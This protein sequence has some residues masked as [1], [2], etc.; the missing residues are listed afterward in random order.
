MW[1]L[2]DPNVMPFITIDLF[3]VRGHDRTG[4]TL[5]MEPL[6]VFAMAANR[7]VE[8]ERDR[9]GICLDPRCR[10]PFG[11]E[12]KNRGKYCS[13]RCASYVH[14][15]KSR[16]KPLLKIVVAAKKGRAFFQW[17][18]LE[19]PRGDT[20]TVQ[21]AKAHIFDRLC[22][23]YHRNNRTNDLIDGETIRKDKNIPEDVFTWALSE[24]DSSQIY[25]EVDTKIRLRLGFDGVQ[26]CQDSTN[27]FR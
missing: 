20:M 5:V 26:P 7:I 21:E 19:T 3:N 9:F 18:M 14:M 1:K 23:Q 13:T 6:Q 16:G 27:P 4:D 12:R 11:S 15:R 10:K 17:K 22:S 2:Y 24:L 25:V 8:R